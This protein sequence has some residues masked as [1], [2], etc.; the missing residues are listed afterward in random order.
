M[1]V[2]IWGF[3]GALPRVLVSL[4]SEAT[5]GLPGPRVLAAQAAAHGAQA[6][7]HAPRSCAALALLPALKL[8]L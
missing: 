8:V 2:S 7:S 1:S 6:V 5:L 4:L 3:M